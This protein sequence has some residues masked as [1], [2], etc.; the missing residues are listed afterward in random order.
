MVDPKTVDEETFEQFSEVLADLDHEIGNSVMI[1]DGHL[2]LHREESDGEKLFEGL[3][4]FVQTT[5]KLREDAFSEREEKVKKVRFLT[6]YATNNHTDFKDM[7]CVDL[8]SHVERIAGVFRDALAYQRKREG[9]EGSENL[10][11][12]ELLE[13]LENSYRRI[14]SDN[15]SSSF[16]YGGLEETELDADYGL[17]MITWTLGKNWEDHTSKGSD[18]LEFG[19]DVEETDCFYEID[20]WDTGEG[21]YSE[22]PGEG[23]DKRS[24]YKMASSFFNSDEVSGQGLPMAKNIADLYD[25]DIFYSEEMLEDEGFGVKIKVPKY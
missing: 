4:E 9:V 14:G 11:I 6:E 12:G 13:P 16:D 15:A 3:D 24:R 20:V 17:R 25:V 7:S 21:L 5:K 8:G 10:D 2:N 23:E 22:F 19:F 18:G 1:L